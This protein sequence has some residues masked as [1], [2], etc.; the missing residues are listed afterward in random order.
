MTGFFKISTNWP[1]ILRELEIKP[2]DV[3]RRANLPSDLL[4]RS[5][6]RISGEEYFR[7][8]RGLEEEA[9]EH[10]VALSIGKSATI[11]AFDPAIFAA[12]CSPNLNSAALRLS[13]FKH[14]IGP[15]EL[16]IRIS[17]QE[18]TLTLEYPGS[19]PIPASLGLAELVFFV[20]F[21]RRATRTELK[22]IQVSVAEFT[23]SM[24]PFDRFFGTKV[25]RGPGYQIAF[26]EADARQ[27]FL[28][29]NAEIWRYFEPVLSQ[30]LSDVDRDASMQDRVR[31]ALFELLPGGRSEL[32]HVAGM[33]GVSTRSLQRRLRENGA[34]YKIILNKTREELARYYLTRSSMPVAEI[35]FL[36]GF[37]EPNSFFRA[38]RHWTGQS[39]KEFRASLD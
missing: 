7:L 13:Q 38:F 9:K 33:L 19:E 39:P 5:N 24:R 27:P 26:S 29:A 32:K 10:P 23:Q 20:Q 34:T 35:S 15:L 16:D 18:T 37:N 21:A 31:A 3:L 1:L 12:F 11:E 14:L 8:W 25:Q 28:T 2:G 6:V 22:P 30:R 4:A 36:L 17:S